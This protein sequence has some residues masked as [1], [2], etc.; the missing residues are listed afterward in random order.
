MIRTCLLYEIITPPRR[1]TRV[2]FSRFEAARLSEIIK[3]T[4]GGTKRR[5]KALA[6]II[7]Q[8]RLSR[9]RSRP[10]R[11]ETTLSCL[12]PAGGL[13]AARQQMLPR[14]P[15]EVAVWVRR[16][17]PWVMVFDAGRRLAST[18]TLL[19]GWAGI[20]DATAIRPFYTGP[21]RFAALEAWIWNEEHPKPG[22]LTRAVLYGARAGATE[23]EQVLLSAP[24][25]ESKEL[26]R[27]LRGTAQGVGYLTFVCPLFRGAR[28]QL[29]C[30]LYRRG[31][32]TVYGKDQTWTDVDLLLCELEAV[33]GLI[34]EKAGSQ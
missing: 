26:Y 11:L 28:R 33:I 4:R 8:E 15:V 19:V 29:T 18:A 34:Q 3:T 10:H 16:T 23:Y 2:D 20:G 22:Y 6:D 14:I 21:R 31:C 30:R 13:V 24:Y 7:R 17:S 25:L 1:R 5:A 9:P 12:Y 32:L 27:E